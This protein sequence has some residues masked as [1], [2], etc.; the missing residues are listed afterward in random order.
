MTDRIKQPYVG[1]SGVVNPEIEASLEAMAVECGLREKNRILA[2]GVKA[3]HKTQY[4]DIENKYGKDWYPVG[5]DSFRHSLR[6]DNLNPD[7]IG[8]AQAYFDIKHVHERE[9][10]AR[11]LGRIIQRGEPWLQAIQFDMLPW[12]SNDEMWDFLEDVKQSEVDTFLQVHGEAM[13][14]LGPKDSV[15]AL[16]QHSELLDY[17]LFDSSHGTGKRLDSLA[18]EPFIAEAHEK[19]DLSQTGIAIAGGLNSEIVRE[20]MPQLLSRY[21]NLSWDAEG[22]LHP[23]NASGKRPLDLDVARSYLHASSVAVDVA[24][25]NISQEN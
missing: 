25:E 8:V 14:T 15:R 20:D 19:L 16:S 4:L 22:R 23:E 17:V 9:Y 18:L 3:V 10:R 7:T 12:H 11:F 5:E 1:V 13:N 2:L 24:A 6:H 21:P